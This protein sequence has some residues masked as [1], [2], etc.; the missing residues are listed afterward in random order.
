[1]DSAHVLDVVVADRRDDLLERDTQFQ[2]GQVRAEAMVA[3]DRST[4]PRCT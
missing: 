2:L 4:P 1:V 3:A